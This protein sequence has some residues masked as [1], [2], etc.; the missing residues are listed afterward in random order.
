MPL[1]KWKLNRSG[2]GQEKH[3]IFVISE[4]FLFLRRGKF[5]QDHGASSGNLGFAKWKRKIPEKWKRANASFIDK[6]WFW[7]ISFIFLE[8]V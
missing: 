7:Q 2:L 4:P 6:I 8:Q 3:Y 1:G 5:A